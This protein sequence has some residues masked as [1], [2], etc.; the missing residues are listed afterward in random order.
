MTVTGITSEKIHNIRE[1]F[2]CLAMGTACRSTAGTASN[3]FS[4]RS[5]AI[6]TL[7]LRQRGRNNQHLQSKF[8]LVDL[9]GSERVKKSKVSGNRLKVRK[10]SLGLN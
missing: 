2:R 3:E 5:H 7:V 6:F 1:I 8:H 9:A 10:R 4:S